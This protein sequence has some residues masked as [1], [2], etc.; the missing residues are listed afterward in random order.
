MGGIELPCW[1]PLESV[2][3][4]LKAVSAS[5]GLNQVICTRDS[6]G[7]DGSADAGIG[8]DKANCRSQKKK[9]M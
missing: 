8:T 6:S 7:L 1:R 3:S 5:A 9:V 4:C 2:H